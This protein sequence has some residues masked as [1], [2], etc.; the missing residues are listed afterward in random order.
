MIYQ[1]S[2][3]DANRWALFSGDYNPIHFNIAH[4]RRQGLE[5]LAVHGM[6]AMLDMKS[7]LSQR[8]LGQTPEATF[9]KFSARLRKP[10]HCGFPYRLHVEENGGRLNGRMQDASDGSECFTARLAPAAPLAAL[11][12]SVAS[13]PLTAQEEAFPGEANT[14]AGYWGF[15]DAVLFQH[16]LAA[17]E[18]L[19][20]VNAVEPAFQ[21][22]S[23]MEVFSRLPVVQTHH[24][25]LFSSELFSAKP[26]A[27][28]RYAIL[29][30]QVL[31]D[32]QQG[33]V[34]SAGIQAWV[35]PDRPLM[36]TT[37]T[38]KTQPLAALFD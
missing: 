18:L 4:A 27:T 30:T 20:V 21:A 25:V 2:L 33:L 29:P 3:H 32:K 7:L 11:S 26:L 38:L 24:E 9:Y 23:M 13:S 5:H 1:Y 31:G 17:P 34:V 22:T 8:L 6:R 37:I 28:L 36:T 16:L 12:A 10:L 19:Q 15:L 35:Q 14:P